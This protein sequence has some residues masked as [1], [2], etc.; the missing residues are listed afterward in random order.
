MIK[1]IAAKLTS[2]LQ[3][4]IPEEIDTREITDKDEE[5]LAITLNQL[6]ARMQ[7]IHDFIFPLSKGELGKIK[8]SPKN[9]LGSPF[10][11]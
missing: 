11:E 7:E 10:K 4:K 9:F 5:D 8:M 3:G 1:R 6:I 2:L